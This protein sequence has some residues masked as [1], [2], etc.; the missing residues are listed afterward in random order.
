ML[1]EVLVLRALF[2]QLRDLTKADSLPRLMSKFA[3]FLHVIAP[4][5]AG[6]EYAVYLPRKSIW[7][8]SAPVACRVFLTVLPVAV[9][10]SVVLSPS[11]SASSILG[12]SLASPSLAAAGI[13]SSLRHLSPLRTGDSIDG[14]G[15]TKHSWRPSPIRRLQSQ[16]LR[17]AGFRRPKNQQEPYVGTIAKC[18]ALGLTQKD[19][20]RRSMAV[21]A[22][23]LVRKSP[24]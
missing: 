10:L 5:L 1:Q 9:A 15:R 3:F 2:E 17:S 20:M 6:P 21:K 14:V 19:W 13:G 11:S 16:M 7:R 4:F 22:S 23:S 12:I 24:V 8:V 18:S